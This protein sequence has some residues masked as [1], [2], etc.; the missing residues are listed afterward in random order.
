[1]LS[2]PRKSRARTGAGRSRSG[3]WRSLA[4]APRLVTNRTSRVLDGGVSAGW[5]AK[6]AIRALA[7][8]R[9]PSSTAAGQLGDEPE[10]G[11]APGALPRWLFPRRVA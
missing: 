10:P 1:M 7:I 9:M 4:L 3:A 2:S 8:N 11:A 6:S 5:L